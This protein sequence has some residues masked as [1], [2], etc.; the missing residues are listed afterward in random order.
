MFGSEA[1]FYNDFTE[2]TSGLVR[3]VT[4]YAGYLNRGT[5]TTPLYCI[6][7]E[8]ACPPNQPTRCFKRVDG[9]GSVEHLLLAMK[10]LAA[11]HAR[12]WGA[13]NSVPAMRPFAHPDKGGGPMPTLPRC[14]AHTRPM[15]WCVRE[16]T[17]G[18]TRAPSTR[19]AQTTR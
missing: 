3:P 5:C 17:T 13:D 1:H 2:E 10:T 11:F 16:S 9:C 7:M 14:V 8:S 18:A 15:V 6:I 4:L 19:P 12:W